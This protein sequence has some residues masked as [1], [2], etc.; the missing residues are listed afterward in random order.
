[1]RP[2]C[3]CYSLST[4]SMSLMNRYSKGPMHILLSSLQEVGGFQLFLRQYRR[5]TRT[6]AGQTRGGLVTPTAAFTLPAGSRRLGYQD[7]ALPTADHTG[8]DIAGGDRPCSR[9]GAPSALFGRVNSLRPA[10]CSSP[11]EKRDNRDRLR[12]LALDKVLACT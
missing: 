12:N 6:R 2:R 7:L 10:H 4:S 9:S 11:L 1:M 3:R 5:P 8:N